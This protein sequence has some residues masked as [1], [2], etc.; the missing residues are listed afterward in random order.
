[1]KIQLTKTKTIEIGGGGHRISDVVGVDLFS[2]VEGGCPA[3]RIAEKKGVLR[4]VAAGLVPPPAAPL[5]ESWEQA[6]KS[7][8][9]SLPQHFQSPHA[10]LAVSS[11]ALFVGQTTMEAF[12]ADFSAGSHRQ[13]ESA[14]QGTEAAKSRRIGIRRASKPAAEPAQNAAPTAAQTAA[15]AAAVEPGIPISNGGTRFVMKKMPV[16]GDFVM[17]AAIPEYQLLWLSRLLPEGRRPT[18]A[19]IQPRASAIAAS[20]LRQSAFTAAGGSAIALFVGE[21]AVNIAGYRGG[22]LVLWRTC[23][24]APGRAGIYGAVKK[25]LGLD[26]DMVESVL[27]DALIDPRP[28]LEP[29]VTPIVDELAVSRDYLADKLRIESPAAFVFG[30]PA[31]AGYFSSIAEERAHMKLAAPEVF[32]GIDGEAPKGAEAVPYAGALGAALALMAEEDG[33]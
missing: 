11:A 33:Q 28:V 9:W 14:A 12:K 23:R 32:D 19:S 21:D 15:P 1:M 31:G 8:I 17:E 3:V 18:A 27:N 4:V 13:D 24:G 10:A 6:A 30:L 5:P 22:D 29:I 7:C 25:G 20:I 2:G 16:D 26:D